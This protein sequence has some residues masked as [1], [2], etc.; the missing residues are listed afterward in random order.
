MC[1]AKRRSFDMRKKLISVNDLNVSGESVIV[2][3][4][5][6]VPVEETPDGVRVVDEQRIK[7][8]VPTV[9]EI[10][11]RGAKRVVIIGHMG[12]DGKR[13]T[14]LLQPLLENLLGEVVSFE[15]KFNLDRGMDGGF[16][17]KGRV[18][19]L[20]NLRL[21]SG[22]KENDPE[23]ASVLSG[24]GGVY[25]N[26]AFGVSHRAHASVVA[27]P[28]K[29]RKERKQ[30]GVGLRFDQEVF[31]LDKIWQIQGYKV[32]IVGG[33]KA[34]DKLGYAISLSSRFDRVLVGGR[35]PIEAQ[36]S[37]EFENLGDKVIMG[38]LREDGLDIDE[39]TISR[40]VEEIEK[41]KVAVVAGP[42]GKYE[43]ADSS[44]GTKD[45]IQAAARYPMYSV[46]CGGD[47]ASALARFVS[48]AQFDWVSVG[49]GA[50]LE[51]LD[52]GNLPGME[53]L[54]V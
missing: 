12:A 48:G 18:V 41:T 6:D 46:G 11:D 47:T 25:V 21:Y 19:L 44:K 52:K 39:A 35:L 22:E 5:L 1:G 17:E 38:K 15:R 23:F 14:S 51:F 31:N 2:R 7:V 36:G 40:F 50:A 33:A 53:A 49:G 26:E 54:S 9:R 10:L 8:A 45:I 30:V 4:D 13:S 16:Q 3:A 24:W 28:E 42:M 27:L 43:E 34:K 20:E 29:M 37:D 32:L